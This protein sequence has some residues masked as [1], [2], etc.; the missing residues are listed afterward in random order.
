MC[1]WFG[2]FVGAYE[3]K[4]VTNN[5]Q[6]VLGRCNDDKE[7]KQQTTNILNKIN[8][9]IN[10]EMLTTTTTTTKTRTRTTTNG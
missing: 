2:A 5:T 7:N 1:V 6:I 8:R 4:M 9:S 10:Y 3:N